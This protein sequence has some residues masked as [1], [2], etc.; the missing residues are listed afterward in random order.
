[1]TINDTDGTGRKDAPSLSP[2]QIEAIKGAIRACERM[3]CVLS[4]LQDN[5]RELQRTTNRIYGLPDPFDV[6]A[7]FDE[8]RP[9]A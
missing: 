7:Q 6:D 8:G 9:V 2:A 3:D 5:V 1:M 4:G